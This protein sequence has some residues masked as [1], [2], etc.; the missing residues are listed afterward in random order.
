MQLGTPQGP[1]PQRDPAAGERAS[2]LIVDDLPEKL[3]VFRTVLEELGQDLVT[4]RSGADALREILKREFAVIMLDVNMPGM[5]GFET[6]TLIRQHRRSAHTPIIFITSYAD[7]IQTAR[8]YS[9]GAV[10]YILSPVVPEILRS[11]VGVFVSLYL[12]QRQ[13]E[14]QVDARAAM[15]AAETARRMAEE[16]DRRSSFLAAA[17]QALSRSLD[18][19]VAMRELTGLLVPTWAAAAVAWVADPE[20]G[21]GQFA[22]AAR[23]AGEGS[24]AVVAG[25]GLGADAAV[26]A[27]LQDST[28]LRQIGRVQTRALPGLSAGALGHPGA[29]PGGPVLNSVA[30]VALHFGE[31]V[32][33]VL[34]VASPD[35]AAW[36][37]EADLNLLQEV[38]TRA[39]AAFENARLYRNLQR[40]IVERQAAQQELQQASQRKDEFLAMLS[41]ELRNP[42]ASV[43]TAIEVIRRV[44]DKH[45]K[46]GWALDLASRQLRQIT[47]LM[48]ELLDVTRISQGKITLKCEPVDLRVVIAHSIETVHPLLE[49]RRQTLGVQMPEA[50]IWVH[51]DG[52]R[53]TQVIA[54][55]LHNAA[56][57]SPESTPIDLCVA[58]VGQDVEVRVRDQGMGIDEELLPRIFDLFA[59]GKRGLDRSQGGLGVGLTLAR[60]LTEMHGGRIEVRSGGRNLGSEFRVTLPRGETVPAGEAPACAPVGTH[61]FQPERILVVDDNLDAAQALATMLEMEGHAVRTA[62]DGEDALASAAEFR[63]DVLLLDIGLPRLDGYEV[64]RRLRAAGEAGVL[65]IAITGYGQHED[66]QAA[67]EAGFDCHFV[68][69]VEADSLLESIR[70]WRQGAPSHA[71]QR[72][73]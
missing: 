36:T 55:L 10:D 1:S 12:M 13:V 69:P 39:G 73:P 56:K 29:D 38:A 66:R 40:E 32:L 54:N 70:A 35:E 18:I 47:R 6:A 11:K 31:R 24:P 51:A 5:D 16:S 17:S 61:P 50:P 62:V 48:E 58:I 19:E 46:V 43:H 71:G 7:E 64:A 3:L 45:P 30:A 42:L 15:M 21:R 41:H 33:G 2:I 26:M 59:Q 20:L 72:A 44:A 34:L 14:R 67:L 53:L 27:V 65:L 52:A 28:A 57:Y 63:P 68:K 8:G 37:H 9:L 49:S 60:R 4:V 22:I 25:T 23:G